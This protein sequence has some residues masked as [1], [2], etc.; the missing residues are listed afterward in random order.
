[1][2]SNLLDN[3]RVSPAARK[4]RISKEIGWRIF[5]HAYNTLLAE[6]GNDM[7]VVQ[8]PMQHVKLS[9]TME[10]YTHLRRGPRSAKSWIYC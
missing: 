5:Q 6:H 2:R 9:T 8:K 10:I 1:M 3:H 7:N 4:A